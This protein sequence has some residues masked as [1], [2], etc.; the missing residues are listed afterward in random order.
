MKITA[1]SRRSWQS[2]VSMRFGLT[3][4][5]ANRPGATAW[6]KSHVIDPTPQPQSSSS[7]PGCK[8]GSRNA[9][10][11]AAVLPSSRACSIEF[12]PCR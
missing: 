2:G 11:V 7:Q 10:E 6:A 9:A 3:V 5:S 12:A 8:C 4:I 1:P